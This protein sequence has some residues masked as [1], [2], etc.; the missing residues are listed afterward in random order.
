MDM[1]GARASALCILLCALPFCAPVTIPGLSTPFG[2]V[3]LLLAARFALG[4]PPWLPRRLRAVSV[5]AKT[6]KKIL[7]AS[8]RLLSW[9]EKR[10]KPRWLWVL[11]VHWKLRVHSAL[12]ALAAIVLMLPLPPVPPL[13][14]TLPALV[15]VLV[16]VG[17]LERDGATVVVGYGVFVGMLIY[18]AFWAGLIAET[19]V[20]LWQRF[21]F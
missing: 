21:G 3:V 11:D 8:S 10:L 19:L 13:T 15:I 18:F 12:I 1:L 14:N 20:R 6:L 17:S 5:S 16:T 4:R 2:L 9:I 7:E